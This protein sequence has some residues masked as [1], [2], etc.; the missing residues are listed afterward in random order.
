MR[1]ASIDTNSHTNGSV[2]QFTFYGDVLVLTSVCL[3]SVMAF[4]QRKAWPQV[5]PGM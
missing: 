4:P 5:L 1:A 3:N 2:V